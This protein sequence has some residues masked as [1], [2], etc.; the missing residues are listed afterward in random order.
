MSMGGKYS[1]RIMFAA[2]VCELISMSTDSDVLRLNVLGAEHI[3][4]NSSEAISDLLDN[5]SAIYS[6]RVRPF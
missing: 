5:R 1:G 6:D 4:L 3:I 2:C